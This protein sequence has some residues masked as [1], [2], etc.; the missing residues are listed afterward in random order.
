MPEFMQLMEGW[1]GYSPVRGARLDEASI[2]RALNLIENTDHMPTHRWEYMMKEAITTSD[3]PML[4]GGIL[5]RELLTRYQMAPIDWKSYIKVGSC[6]DFRQ[7][8]LHKVQGNEKLLP[9]VA[10]K[11]EYLV[12]PMADAHYHIQVGKR[13][14]QFDISWESLINDDLGA[15]SDMP[16]RFAN[17]CLYTEAYVATNQIAVAAGPNPL[18]F[19]ATITDVDGQ[20]VTNQ[21]VLA[22]TIANLETTLGL[23]AAQTDVQGSPLSIRGLHL[24]VP[25][26]LEMT[27]RAILTSAFIQHVDTI[28]AA[29]AN[30]PVYVPLPTTNILPQMGIQ[31]HVNPLLPVLDASGNKNGTW[32]LFAD[33]SEGAAVEFD[34]LKGHES[35]EICMKA[36]D[37]LMVSGAPLGPFSGDFATDNVFYRVRH[38]MGAAPVDPRY[39]YAQVHA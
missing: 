13:G 19:G 22:L 9:A 17:A 4:F 20:A 38:C 1:E 32:Y 12:A 31:L 35:P 28:G 2:A 10:E 16:D 26:L 15:F 11:D 21:G 23:M 34:Y 18:L 6:R 7:R 36:S 30:P 27:A 25:T 3:F 39:A 14:R 5:D 33:S 37:K 8:E 29:N 24:V